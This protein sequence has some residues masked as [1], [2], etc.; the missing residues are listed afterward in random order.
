[1]QVFLVGGAVRDELLGLEVVDRDWVVVGSSP[2]EMVKQGFTPVGKDFPVFLHPKTREEYAL[3]RTERKSAPGYHGFTFHA[4]PDVTLEED[5]ARRDL[6]INAMAR[7]ENGTLI[8]PFGGAKDL[9]AKIFRHVSPAFQEDPV[10]V[11]RLARF[12]AR[13]A[14]FTLAKETLELAKTIVQSQE[15]KALVPERVWS[16]VAKGLMEPTPSRLFEVLMDCGAFAVLC[17]QLSAL[18]REPVP[19]HVFFQ[20]LNAAAKA[21]TTTTDATTATNATASSDLDLRF[22]LCFY[23][24][25]TLA[26]SATDAESLCNALKA[27]SHCKELALLVLQLSQA[28]QHLRALNAKET[29][30][31][32]ESL[33]GLR[34]PTR[35]RQALAACSIAARCAGHE[36][37]SV[38]L[39][40][41]ALAFDHTLRL[42]TKHLSALALQKGLQGT[43]VGEFL[44]QSRLEALAHFFQTD[45]PDKRDSPRI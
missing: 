21:A 8:D 9:K 11:L 26:L 25:P 15:I 41:F 35:L 37:L 33:D 5:L 3:A 12:A 19:R 18:Q 36:K 22:A 42:D 40:S 43:A 6:T 31:W 4:S 23:P 34:R 1:M 2:E 30:E 16:E 45:V 32:I 29:L 14:D 28:L 27:P 38:S 7:S 13:F 17:P 10:R 39:T 24:Y 44:H 20:S